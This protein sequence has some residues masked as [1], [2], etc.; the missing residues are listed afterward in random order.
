MPNLINQSGV[1][2]IAFSD[3]INDSGVSFDTRALND[4]LFEVNPGT[5]DFCVHD[6]QF[7]DANGAVVAA[8]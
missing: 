8:P 6:F 4:I 5:F 7:L 2:T 1:V 3:F